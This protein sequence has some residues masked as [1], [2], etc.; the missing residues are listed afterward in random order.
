[1]ADRVKILIQRRTSLKSQITNLSNALDKG[2]SDNVALKLR[3]KRLTELYHAFEDYNDELSVLDPDESH[4]N[5]FSNIQ[6]RFYTLA[7]KLESRFERET[8]V[9]SARQDGNNRI[10]D[11]DAVIPIKRRRIKLPEATLPTFD[12][13]YES[14]LS[15]KNAFHN[16]IGSQTDLSDIDKLHYLKSA[17]IGEAASKVRIFEVDG[18]NYSKAWDVLERSYEV[19]RVLI[20]RHLSSILNTLGLEKETSS[21]LSRLADDTQQHVA[22][23]NTLGVSVGQE[24]IVHILETKLPKITL[25]KWEITLD[26]DSFPSADQM[27]EFLYKTAVCASKRERTR[28]VEQEKTRV[29]TAIKSKKNFVPNRAFVTN[30]TRSCV[31][32]KDKRHPLY[33]CERFKQLPVPKRIETVKNAKLCYNCLRSHKGAPCKFS[34]CT[35]CQRRH[36][37]LIHQ[38][39]YA[40]TIASTSKKLETV[41]TD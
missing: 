36:N 31:I 15:F 32:C 1:M 7:A 38:N 14:W 3:M 40:G 27:Y 18:I 16:M 24:M 20:S 26:R 12:G 5:E 9:E 37:T 30:V 10:D 13:K 23:L 41:K 39:D 19:K 11:T 17:L 8:S 34:S 29:E 2:K 6:E 25:E 21:G 33:L 35:I 28:P 22:A 4:Q